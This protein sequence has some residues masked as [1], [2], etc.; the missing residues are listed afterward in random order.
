MQAGVPALLAY[1]QRVAETFALR[2]TAKDYGYFFLSARE[3]VLLDYLGGC[4]GLPHSNWGDDDDL[5]RQNLVAFVE[6]DDFRDYS[7]E[8][9]SA[10]SVLGSET[11]AHLRA[12]CQA[13]ILPAWIPALLQTLESQPAIEQP[14]F[15]VI[16]LR[17]VSE[18]V[19]RRMHK[20]LVHEWSH[21]L[22]YSNGLKFQTTAA[23]HPDAWLFDEGLA[24]WIEYAYLAGQWD[25]S[26]Q[27]QEVLQ[28]LQKRNKPRSVTGYFEKGLWFNAH[29]GALPLTAWAA[30]LR[31][32]ASKLPPADLA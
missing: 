2:F 29:F 23:Q 12:C 21:L 3:K 32:L 1:L 10:G 18:A 19:L 30:E 31:E 24:T 16:C 15:V 27:Q 14:F 28:W 7:A 8:L 25:C 26:R 5:R 17:E 6:S 22:F 13:L 20:L 11:V 4:P 9:G